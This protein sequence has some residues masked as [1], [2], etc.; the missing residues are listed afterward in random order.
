MPWGDAIGP[1]AFEASDRRRRADRFRGGAGVGASA[2]GNTR[3]GKLQSWLMG[4][5]PWDR[6]VGRD[7]SV[8]I[9]MRTIQMG[10]P[11]PQGR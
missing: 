10:T 11:K 7:G 8:E 4:E 1:A 5:A 3:A 9:A 2:Q 6:F